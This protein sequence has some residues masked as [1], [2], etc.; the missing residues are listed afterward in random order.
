MPLRWSSDQETST[1]KTVTGCAFFPPY[2]SS[3]GA[4]DPPERVGKHFTGKAS[5]KLKYEER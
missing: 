1:N 4:L 5:L 3:V 2:G